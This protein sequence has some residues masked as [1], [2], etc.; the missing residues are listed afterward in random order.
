M[1]DVYSLVLAAEAAV[2]VVAGVCIAALATR[3][4]DVV[5]YSR[6]LVFAGVGLSG[7]GVATVLVAIDGPP[8][9]PSAL[10]AIAAV[11]YGLAGWRIATDTTA[12]DRDDTYVMDTA[13]PTAHGFEEDT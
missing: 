3:N 10:L 12:T 6:A 9:L 5:L 2:I 7:G 4:A 1:T 13:E 11:P 8:S